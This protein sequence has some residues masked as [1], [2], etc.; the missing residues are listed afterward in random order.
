ML[1]NC[2]TVQESSARVQNI[3][4]ASDFENSVSDMSA[5][6]PYRQAWK[7]CPFSLCL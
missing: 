7:R 3:K 2:R 6:I 1:Q 4:C 5:C